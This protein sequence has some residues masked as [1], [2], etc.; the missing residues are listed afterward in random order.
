MLH[1]LLVLDW[2]VAQ[3]N[4]AK[5]QPD[6]HRY[7]VNGSLPLDKAAYVEYLHFGGFCR[8]YIIF[9]Q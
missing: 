2:T 6:N 8:I 5:D 1:L 3:T 7:Y 9:L 4:V